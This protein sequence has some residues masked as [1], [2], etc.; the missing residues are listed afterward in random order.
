[1][2][3]GRHMAFEVTWEIG[4]TVT[5]ECYN[6]NKGIPDT[7]VNQHVFQSMRWVSAVPSLRPVKELLVKTKDW[8]TITHID[9]EEISLYQVIKN[10]YNGKVLSKIAK[11][12]YWNGN[13][14]TGPNMV[15]RLHIF[16]TEATLPKVTVD[17]L[18][19]HCY[20]DV[21]TIDYKNLTEKGHPCKTKMN[22]ELWEI[23]LEDIPK[24]LTGSSFPKLRR[25]DLILKYRL[26]NG[27]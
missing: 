12:I 26:E 14:Y 3:K 27:L 5:V 7:D 4:E 8:E 22:E 1:M 9:L 16:D 15:H 10:F 17:N 25:K 20:Y 19:C 24:H 13:L 11:Q 18:V 2:K 23:P 6:E 21:R